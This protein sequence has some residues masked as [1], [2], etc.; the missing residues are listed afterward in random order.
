MALVPQ[1]EDWAN[2]WWRRL[3]SGF[4]EWLGLGL[5]Y[6]EAAKRDRGQHDHGGATPDA[7][8]THHQNDHV[9]GCV[10]R[11]PLSVPIT[12]PR[13]HPVLLPS[14]CLAI[15]PYFQATSVPQLSFTLLGCGSCVPH[16]LLGLFVREMTHPKVRP[17]SVSYAG[18]Y[19]CRQLAK[20]M[21]LLPS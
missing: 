17:N 3:G 21:V 18:P 7:L 15:L 16:V 1:V 20:G 5:V 12:P 2:W 4:L 8:D 13:L 19:C 14:K 11:C 9:L 10:S 6:E